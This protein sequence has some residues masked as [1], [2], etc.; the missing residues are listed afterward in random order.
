M[1]AFIYSKSSNWGRNTYQTVRCSS[2]H[3]TEQ[4][5]CLPDICVHTGHCPPAVVSVSLHFREEAFSCGFRCPH[6]LGFM[7]LFEVIFGWLFFNESLTVFSHVESEW[8][9]PDPGRGWGGDALGPGPPRLSCFSPK[10][11][12]DNY[13]QSWKKGFPGGVV[14]KNPPANAGD[15]GSIP[16]PGRSCRL[17]SN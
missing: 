16:G 17:R 5:L 3:K 10:G 2:D 12:T 8:H 9:W 4:N 13:W 11:H 6:N 1:H 14:V 15:M 7:S